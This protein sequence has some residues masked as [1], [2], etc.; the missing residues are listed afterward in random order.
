[1]YN[2]HNDFLIIPKTKA[3]NTCF[4]QIRGCLCI[5]L[6]MNILNMCN[7]SF[8]NRRVFFSMWNLVFGRSLPKVVIFRSFYLLFLRLQIIYLLLVNCEL[9]Q[10]GLQKRVKRGWE[11]RF[12]IR[13]AKRSWF[14]FFFFFLIYQIWCPKI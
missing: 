14:P 4:H 6:Y 13:A 1:M 9:P 11:A 8:L 7:G 3:T 5:P 10:K 2:V 12:V